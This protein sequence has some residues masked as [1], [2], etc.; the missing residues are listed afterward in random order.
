MW[1][2][3]YV[4]RRQTS[5]DQ[6]SVFEGV[7]IDISGEKDADALREIEAK[8]RHA[9]TLLPELQEGRTERGFIQEALAIAEQLTDSQISFLHFVNEDASIELVAWSQHTEESYCNAAYN[10]HYP[11]AQ[12]GIWAEAFRT[13][14]PFVVNDYA[15]TP[16][17]NGLPEGHA[18]LQRFISLP[19]VDNDRTVVL[20]GVGNAPR[21]YTQEDVFSLQIILNEV[22]RLV[23]GE[24]QR[25]RI[26]D[27]QDRLQTFFNAT[28]DS[29][30]IY[31]NSD[32]GD[33]FRVKY[34]NRAAEEI[35]SVEAKDTI[36]RDFRDVWPGVMSAGIYSAIK[37]VWQT[38]QTMTKL[39]VHYLHGNVDQWYDMTAARLPD[40]SVSVV[41]RD[42]TEMVRSRTE[43]I[44]LEK[45]LA[46]SQ[47]M[48]AL[49]RLAG[50]VAHDFNNLLGVIIGHAEAGQFGTDDLSVLKKHLEHV[51]EAALRS[52]EMT[53]QLL[54]FARRQVGQ[55]TRLDLGRHL[56]TLLSM[57]RR[58]IGEN[59]VLNF[60]P[61]ETN[62]YV[63][64]DP[65]F[66]DQVITNL[67]V[68]S[69]DAMVGP[70]QV[71]LRLERINKA[72]VDT[73]WL[74]ECVLE[75]YLCMSVIDT[76]HGIDPAIM[77]NIFEPFFSTKE[78]GTRLGLSTVFG[79]VRQ[80][81]GHIDIQSTVGIG[82]TVRIFLPP[83][84]ESAL[85]K[86]A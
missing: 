80:L 76:G 57:L 18:P 50:G 54:G 82:T 79:I 16:I 64:A 83:A 33:V 77:S 25:K 44:R 47:R 63:D 53:K 22:W 36:G 7:L 39:E 85:P 17:K 32:N 65:T 38:G 14:K 8:R 3:D 41:Y 58:L 30:V 86:E 43:S 1:F 72:S 28:Y 19:V 61:P 59:V 66:I 23:G 52:A 11:L 48:E 75:E 21:D 26:V 40:G 10:R 74:D 35:G 15:A 31:E 49:G 73:S 84:L 2:R 46:A 12:A 20:A 62:L 56:R 4:R 51:A 45:E 67:C 69:R 78:S 34:L 81:N 27:E 71:E 13:R 42:V 37:N 9:L 6:S 29:F 60:E 68:N 5:A 70:G 24:R 55:P